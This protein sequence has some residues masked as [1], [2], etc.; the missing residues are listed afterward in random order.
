MFA[1]KNT[2]AKTR[3]QNKK[4]FDIKFVVS[5][6]AERNNLQ[7]SPEKFKKMIEIVKNIKSAHL[8]LK[9]L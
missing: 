6:M 3:G 2:N 5:N 4:S 8:Y 9:L 7:K 1:P